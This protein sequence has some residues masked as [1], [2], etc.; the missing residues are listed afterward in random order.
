M[1]RGGFFHPSTLERRATDVLR[2]FRLAGGALRPPIHA[3]TLLDVVYPR[4][5]NSPLWDAID[6]PPGSAILG[7]LAPGQRLI[8]L[9]E[10][11]RRLF[12]ETFGL[13]NTTI[14]HEIAHWELHVDKDLLDHPPLPGFTYDLAFTCLRGGPAS[15]DEKNAHRF[16]GFLLLPS[17][18]F[19]PRAQEADLTSWRGLYALR[20][21]FE[22]TI[23][24]LKLRLHD[25]GFAYVDRDGTIHPSREEAMGQRRLL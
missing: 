19:V 18:L 14:A 15:W 12:E 4:E 22:V 13:V 23:T 2:R 25:L 6:E 24:A 9:N 10:R 5:L 7:G 17:E 11:R 8:V 20:D 3:E 16:M 1:R 21:E